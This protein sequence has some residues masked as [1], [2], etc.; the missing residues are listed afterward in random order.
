MRSLAI[1]TLLL[2]ASCTT[3]FEYSQDDESEVED[4]DDGSDFD[5]LDNSRYRIASDAE[6]ERVTAIRDVAAGMGMTNAALMG[7]IAMVETGLAHCWSEAKWACKG[8]SSPACGGGPV[9]AGSGDGACKKKRGGLGLYQFDAGTHADTLKRDGEDIL[10]VEGNIEHAVEFVSKILDD[11]MSE[12]ASP[13]AAIEYMNGLQFDV[14][15]AK[16]NAWAKTVA[17]R[18]NGCCKNTKRCKARRRGYRDNAIKIYKKYGADFWG[19]KPP[20]PDCP[21]V[22]TAG[23]VIDEDDACFTPGGPTKYL[24][25]VDTGYGGSSLWTYAIAK[26]NGVVS[27]TWKI[28]VETPGRYRVSVHMDGAVHA[29]STQA[30][31][32]VKHADG[33]SD[34]VFN[35]VIAGDGFKEL[36]EFNLSPKVRQTIELA[37]NTGE[38]SAD[39]IEVLFDAIELVR[40]GDF[41]DTNTKEIYRDRDD[42]DDADGDVISGCAASGGRGTSGVLGLGLALAAVVANRR[43][44]RS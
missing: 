16:L 18:Y 41:D 14:S 37:D 40:V 19:G 17:C 38:S 4:V 21:I 7:G 1:C 36:G 39:K 35:Q 24:R 28:F 23:R 5:K 10:M 11:G 26:P 42:E 33:I 15:D 27:G 6:F 25:A 3:E 30:K 31:Y 32:V 34:V 44:R 29:K 43:R 8:P 13:A 2:L 20:T 9:I 12:V 22:P